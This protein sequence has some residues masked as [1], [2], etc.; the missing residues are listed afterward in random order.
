MVLFDFK[1][2]KH[3]VASSDRTT[4]QV[5]EWINLS[6]NPSSIRNTH[7]EEVATI[8]ARDRDQ[9][10]DDDEE[11]EG[12]DDD[13]ETYDGLM[14]FDGH[15]KIEGR[16]GLTKLAQH[17]TRLQLRVSPQGF[18]F[19][20]VTTLGEHKAFGLHYL[21]L[22][23]LFNWSSHGIR[24][25]SVATW[26]RLVLEYT[27][28]KREKRT[29][30]AG[31]VSKEM[32]EEMKKAIGK[33]DEELEKLR[34]EV[35]KLKGEKEEMT[36]ENASE[37]KKL[38]N[39]LL[40][41]PQE[42]KQSWILTATTKLVSIFDPNALITSR[43]RAVPWDT[44]NLSDSFKRGRFVYDPLNKIGTDSRPFP[45]ADRFF[46]VDEDPKDW[47]PP[48]KI[49]VSSLCGSFDQE[50][51]WFVKIAHPNGGL[52]MMAYYDGNTVS[53]NRVPYAWETKYFVAD[54]ACTLV[55][56]VSL[57]LD[58]KVYIV[59][60]SRK[61]MG[62]LQGFATS[63][64]GLTFNVPNF[65]KERIGK[66]DEE[67]EKPREEVEKL[68]GEKLEMTKKNAT[69]TKK[70]RDQLSQLPQEPEQRR[71]QSWL[72]TATTKLVPLRDPTQTAQIRS[73]RRPVPQ[74]TWSTPRSEF[75]WGNFWYGRKTGASNWP[76]TSVNSIS[77]VDEDPKDW[78]PPPKIKVNIYNSQFD[79]DNW[80]F[81]KTT[82]PNGGL[83]MMA[84]YDGNN[85][86]SSVRSLLLAIR[87]G[88]PT[89]PMADHGK[90][91]TST[92]TTA[93][94]TLSDLMENNNSNNYPFLWDGSS[95]PAELLAGRDFAKQLKLQLLDPP[96]PS[97]SSSDSAITT[98]TSSSDR[99]CHP[100]LQQDNN[101]SQQQQ[102]TGRQGV[103]Q[104]I[105]ESFDNALSLLG[106]HD[107]DDNSH[108]NKWG[109]PPPP[110]GKAA[111]GGGVPPTFKVPPAPVKRS[112]LVSLKCLD[113]KHSDLL[114]IPDLSKAQKLESLNLEGCANLVGISSI[115]YLTK[116]QH[117]NLKGCQSLKGVPSLIRLKL[118]KTFDLSDCSNLTRLPPSLG[119]LPNLSELNLKNCAKL[120]NLP[121]SVIHLMKSL[122]TLNIS[123]CSSMWK[124]IGDDQDGAVPSLA[125]PHL[126]FSAMP[127]T[128]ARHRENLPN[129]NSDIPAN[130]E[131][132]REQQ[133]L[134]AEQVDVVAEGSLSQDLSLDLKDI[135]GKKAIE[136]EEEAF[137]RTPLISSLLSELRRAL[138]FPPNVGSSHA[139][140]SSSHDINIQTI[141]HTQN[142]KSEA[143]QSEIATLLQME[144]QQQ[145]LCN[146]DDHDHDD[147]KTDETTTLSATTEPILCQVEDCQIDLSGAETYHQQ[148]KI[149]EIHCMATAALLGNILQR[150]CQQCCRFHVL[151]DFDEEERNCRSRLAGYHQKQ[152]RQRNATIGTK[153]E[154][155]SPETAADLD[156]EINIAES[157]DENEKCLLHKRIR[158]VDPP[159]QNQ[160]TQA[161][162]EQQSFNDW[163]EANAIGD[164]EDRVLE[165]IE[166]ISRSNC[167]DDDEK[168]A[169]AVPESVL[170]LLAEME[171]TVPETVRSM[172][173]AKAK[174]TANSA[175]WKVADARL[176]IGELELRL[177]DMELTRIS[178]EEE[179]IEAELQRLMD[180]K[181]KLSQQQQQH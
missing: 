131:S 37:T 169:A 65:T 52:T 43:R 152:R 69:E 165:M 60:T 98:T 105:L 177:L 67:L 2:D 83:T 16:E 103:V 174:A 162:V 110:S 23:D 12:D 47:P 156:A 70:L 179:E 72:L 84:Y 50:N 106:H 125:K 173:S 87:V 81:V 30:P 79:I 89:T 164:I 94:R 93:P 153:E 62:L 39:Q 28:P 159:E 20:D 91:S 121:R 48:P 53:N 14:F 17:L 40:Q 90:T 9:S 168:A 64:Q 95:L 56:V 112:H 97:C 149:C 130:K 155:S 82:H 77:L 45:R 166:Q 15:G 150:F 133:L 88:V 35:E 8:T 61:E 22:N 31:G 11:D 167:A 181:R 38:R 34:E 141:N 137:L 114:W 26:R 119:C 146:D 54:T 63:L 135:R 143:E 180:Q 49:T 142:N 128:E 21:R 124:Y 122:E 117:L 139:S 96:L 171:Q 55:Y 109:S 57:F 172:K 24:T 160:P 99:R 134:T 136:R 6:V 127:S 25:P 46:L 10:D 138:L 42:K 178:E 151:C 123:G 161:A 33:K 58:G 111:A 1:S 51:W 27:V 3:F 44:W 78:L 75:Q 100:E 71:K 18:C 170:D 5:Y 132:S 92:N 73:R 115:Q 147:A 41:L 163:D 116:L 19:Q 102:S 118:L 59:P 86:I 76:F 36:K 158:T 144:D 68:K 32:Y 104:E 126:G 129:S 66:K 85:A 175:E 107:I 108:L 13:G 74:D 154:H 145:Q 157:E 101:K 120:A 29:T 4:L 113:A 7:W 140:T 148:H 176:V 80:W